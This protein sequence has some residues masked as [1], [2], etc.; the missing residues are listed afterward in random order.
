MIAFALNQKGL[1]NVASS[2]SA[3]AAMVAQRLPN[4]VTGSVVCGLLAA[5]MSSLA[6]LFNSSRHVICGGFYKK[7]V[8]DRPPKHYVTVGVLPQRCFDSWNC[9]DSVMLGLGKC[10]TNTSKMFRD[11]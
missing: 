3:F 9:L 8:P 7:M 11:C 1:L 2:D 4:G 6:S 5:L 10:S